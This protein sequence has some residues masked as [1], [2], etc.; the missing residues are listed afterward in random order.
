[1][2]DEIQQRLIEAIKNKDKLMVSVLRDIKGQLANAEKIKN[3][4]LTEQDCI[5]CIS[6]IAKKRKQTIDSCRGNEKYADMMKKEINELKI[7]EQYLPKPMSTEEIENIVGRII[8]DN[9]ITGDMKN[10]GTVMKLFTQQYTGQD[11]KVVSKVVREVLT[12]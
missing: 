1:M 5:N 2:K 8:V 6:S 9:K 7:V 4:P 10:L 3:K 12:Q 11:G